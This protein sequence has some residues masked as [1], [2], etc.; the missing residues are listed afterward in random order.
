MESSILNQCLFE[1]L[2]NNFIY[3]FNMKCIVKLVSIQHPVLIP[4]GALLS[5]HHPPPL[6]LPLIN[7][8]IVL[9]F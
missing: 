6:L 7:P 8:Q 2:E 3:F 4:T 1:F 5:A 9:S